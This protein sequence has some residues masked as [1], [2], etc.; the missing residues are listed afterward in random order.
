MRRIESTSEY[1]LRKLIGSVETVKNMH[2]SSAKSLKE[3][4]GYFGSDRAP[5]AVSI[6]VIGGG[7]DYYNTDIIERTTIIIT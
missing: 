1:Y 3:T 4:V 6:E 5:H 7:T 2:L